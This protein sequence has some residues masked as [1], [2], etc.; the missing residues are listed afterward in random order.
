MDRPKDSSK[1]LEK[2]PKERLLKRMDEHAIEYIFP[3]KE[4]LRELNAPGPIVDLLLETNQA[5]SF[6]GFYTVRIAS[7]GGYAKQYAWKKGE[8]AV[9]IHLKIKEQ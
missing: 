7:G 9:L 4:R 1:K 2:H 3:K 6:F 8:D 5:I